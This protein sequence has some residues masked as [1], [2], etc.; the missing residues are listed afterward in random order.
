M[1]EPNSG[2]DQA[3]CK[4]VL[5]VEYGATDD[6]TRFVLD[7]EAAEGISDD[8]FAEVQLALD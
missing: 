2:V 5:R 1:I 8:Q 7:S 3:Y 4:V 6:E